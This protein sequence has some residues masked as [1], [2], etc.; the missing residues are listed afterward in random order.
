MT[1]K[2]GTVINVLDHGYVKLIDYMGSDEAIVEAARMSTGKGFIGWDKTKTCQRCKIAFPVDQTV[3]GYTCT[4][5]TEDHVWQEGPGDAK[6]LEFMYKNKHMTPFEFCELHIEVQ[7]PIMVFREW[8]RHRTHSYS[9]FSARYSQ[10]ANLHYLP[11]AERIQKQSKS[12]RQGGAEAFPADRA[13][14][15]REMLALEQLTVYT[16]YDKL[17]E[18]GVAKEVSRINTPVS[19]YSKMRDK[20]DLRNFL[21]FLILR[22][23][24]AHSNP[25][26][27]I[28]QY[29]DVISEIIQALWPRTYYLFEEYDLF[30]VHLSRTEAAYLREALNRQRDTVTTMN[31]P[32]A[33][34]ALKT[35]GPKFGLVF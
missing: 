9:E 14:E 28:A 20:T 11:E 4:D 12:N 22:K 35:I 29:A 8:H 6:L 19:R 21:A 18:E 24:S 32:N 16:D 34:P 27:E 10:M 25:Q 13:K 30:G 1:I 33:N 2:R 7:A 15:I 17:C 23:Q 26:W 3:L 5:N 31:D